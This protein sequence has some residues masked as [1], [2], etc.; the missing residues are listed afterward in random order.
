MC[1][2]AR[3]TEKWGKKKGERGRRGETYIFQHPNLP[4]QDADLRVILALEL[5]QRRRAEGVSACC[6]STTTTTTA[7]R[8]AHTPPAPSNAVRRIPPAQAGTQPGTRTPARRRGSVPAKWPAVA[9][10]AVRCVAAAA[11]LGFRGRGGPVVA[12]EEVVAVGARE[13]GRVLVWVGS[14]LVRRV[15]LL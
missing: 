14:G 2:S 6:P 13:A 1:L 12:A 9:V 10:P 11:V 5:I 8:L 4:R 7:I 15:A 3:S